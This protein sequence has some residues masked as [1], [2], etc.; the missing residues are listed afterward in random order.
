MTYLPQDLF[1]GS[2]FGLG[3]LYIDRPNTHEEKTKP[4]EDDFQ[5]VNKRKQSTYFGKDG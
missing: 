5:L 1:A 4:N 3:W 2:V